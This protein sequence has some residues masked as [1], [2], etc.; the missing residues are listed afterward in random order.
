MRPLLL[1]LVVALAAST[2]VRADS[3]WRVTGAPG[4]PVFALIATINANKGA[5]WTFQC[6]AETIAVMQT[7]VTDLMDIQTG[8]KVADGPGAVMAPGAAVMGLMSDKNNSGF[9][10]ALTRPNP[11]LGWDMMIRLPKKDRA[12]RGLAKAKLVTVMT[13]G[14]TVAAFIE[15]EDR[16]VITGFL[17]RC[18]KD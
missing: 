12:L 15:P 10:P 11:R 14:F 2:A 1:G 4:D 8:Q 16:L 17:D 7:A 18:L 3:I 13:T 6:E 9:L 5:T